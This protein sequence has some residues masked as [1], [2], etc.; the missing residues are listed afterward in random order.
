MSF[1][2]TTT[3]SDLTRE[4]KAFEVRAAVLPDDHREA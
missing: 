4:W 1:W 2:E 3:G